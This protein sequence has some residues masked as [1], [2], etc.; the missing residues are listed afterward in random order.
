MI[1][2]TRAKERPDSRLQ[3]LSS[4]LP[5]MQKPRFYTVT[6]WRWLDKKLKRE[7]ELE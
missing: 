4:N 2:R 7:F 1:G 6:L 3:R 5:P